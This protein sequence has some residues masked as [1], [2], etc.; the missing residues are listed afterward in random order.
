M[1]IEQ[2]IA[3]IIQS[4]EPAIRRAFERGVAQIRDA[5][6][7][8]KIR[9][10]IASGDIEQVLRI[11]DIDPA[12]F[13]EFRAALLKVYGDSGIATI[14]GQTWFYPDGTRAVVRWNSLSP[15]AEDFARQIGTGLIT[16]I[17][18]DMAT[19]VRNAVADGYAFG[20]SYNRIALDI[21]G[22]IGDNGRR[23]GGIIGLSAPQEQWVRNMRRYLEVWPDWPS[24][25]RMTR[26]DKRFDKI[27]REAYEQGKPLTQAQIDKIIGRYADRLLERRGLTIARTET[28]KAAEEGKYDAWKQGLEK[29]GVPE[30]FVIRTWVHTG[31]AVKD[32]PDHIAMNG[33]MM[34][35]L[36]VPFILPDGTAMLHPHDASY[37]AGAKHTINCMCEARYK[38]D[39]KGLREWQG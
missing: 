20:R 8:A 15:R 1:S 28:R 7:L 5:A 37:G 31:R 2:Q 39:R 36:Q 10:A 16:N 32:R 18:D 27:I 34:R 11:V 23:S 30:R 35:G 19:A 24:I 22:R 3:A 26:R 17:T 12:A 33:S 6:S 4:Q 38:I 9:D 21:V 13:N 29:T 14:Q 25:Q